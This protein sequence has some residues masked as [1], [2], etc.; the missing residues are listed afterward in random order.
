MFWYFYQ[1]FLWS[2]E[3]RKMEYR[4]PLQNRPMECFNG[5][6]AFLFPE[7]AGR[8]LDERAVTYSF[9]AHRRLFGMVFDILQPNYFYHA[10][11]DSGVMIGSFVRSMAI[12]SDFTSPGDVDILVMSYENDEFILSRILVIEIKVIRAT[13]THQQKS[14]NQFGFS[15]A[16]ALLHHG[17]P[18]VAVGHLITSDSSPLEAWREMGAN[19]ILNAVTGQCAPIQMI[20]FDC[21]P[22]DL[23]ERAYG[24]LAQHRPNPNIGIF[25]AYPICQGMFCPQGLPAEPNPYVNRKLLDKVY[26]YYQANYHAFLW[27]R[28]NPPLHKATSKST[29]E[30]LEYLYEKMQK[31]FHIKK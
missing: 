20:Q 31:D 13:F 18:Y 3:R 15:Q 10:P 6:A 7:S 23:L 25:T 12:S 30:Y 5:E 17:F 16:Q 21:L 28:R 1:M 11:Y 24:R 4:R 22:V 14:P 9:L 2:S 8:K 19:K 27:T 26:E 29:D